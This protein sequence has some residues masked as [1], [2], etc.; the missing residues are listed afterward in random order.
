MEGG[1]AGA[2]SLGGNRHRSGA[3]PLG[4]WAEDDM[5]MQGVPHLWTL[6]L[7]H[8]LSLRSPIR[9]GA[10]RRRSGTQTVGDGWGRFGGERGDRAGLINPKLLTLS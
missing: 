1:V 8:G 4:E 10:G 6:A 3:S 7:P 9:G 5:I 2:R